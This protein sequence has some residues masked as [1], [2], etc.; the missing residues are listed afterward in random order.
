MT[1]SPSGSGRRQ[2]PQLSGCTVDVASFLVRVVVGEIGN[3]G[4]V[5]NWRVSIQVSWVGEVHVTETAA[6][7]PVLCAAVPG[8]R[9]AGIIR[10]SI[11]HLVGVTTGAGKR[12]RKAQS[13]VRKDA[14]QVVSVMCESP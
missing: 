7:L 5:I 11:L 14:G 6:E 3:S 2:S 13:V 4:K 9:V 12:R 1:A 8:E 10:L